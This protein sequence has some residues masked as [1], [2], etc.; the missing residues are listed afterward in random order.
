MKSV[1]IEVLRKPLTAYAVHTSTPERPILLGVGVEIQGVK[2][3]YGW[4]NGRDFNY[5]FSAGQYGVMRLYRSWAAP[6]VA[7]VD[8]RPPSFLDK[9]A[10]VLFGWKF[11]IALAIIFGY[12]LYRCAKLP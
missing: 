8:R 3:C 1:T 11:I 9:L 2:T 4:E 10:A 6:S 12:I 5:E 7:V